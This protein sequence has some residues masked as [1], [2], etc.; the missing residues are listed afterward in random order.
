[1]IPLTE[2][3]GAAVEGTHARIYLSNFA[4]AFTYFLVSSSRI[5]A[6]E[7]AGTTGKTRVSN[8]IIILAITTTLTL[9]I[10]I[11]IAK[12][13]A[14][15]ERVLHYHYHHRYHYHHYYHYHHLYY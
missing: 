8:D 9:T 12:G 7:R 15:A 1:M 13:A 10:T 5:R 11:P 14:V 2:A 6:V 4:T 3:P